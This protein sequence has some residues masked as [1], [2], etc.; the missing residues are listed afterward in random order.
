MAIFRGAQGWFSLKVEGGPDFEVYRLSGHEEISRTYEFD[1]ELVSRVPGLDLVDLLGRRAL[2]TMADHSGANRLV[3]GSIRLAEELH[4]ANLFTHYHLVIVPRLWYLGQNRN[5]RIFQHRSVVQIIDEILREQK[6]RC[7][8][9]EWKLKEKYQPREY[10]VQY[11]E[12]DLYF[13]SRL[14]EEE[15]IYYYFEHQADSHVLCFSDASGG[16]DIPNQP[17]GLLRFFPGSGQVADEAVVRNLVVKRTVNSDTASYREWN[18]EKPF[19]DLEVSSHEADQA[20]APAPGGLKLETYQYPHLY[21]LKEPGERYSRIQLAR[22]LTFS[23]VAEGA[24]DVTRLLPGF[25]FKVYGHPRPE[26]NGLWWLT[27]VRH[28]GEQPQVLE[29]EAPERGFTY[30]NSFTAIPFETRFIP[31]LA[32]PKK[33]INGLQSALVTG[34]EG[35]EVFVDEYGRVKVHFHWDRLGPLN[36]RSTRWVRVAADWAGMNF[37]YIQ[38]PRIGQEVLVEFMEG[39]PDRPVVTG[40]VYK[41][42]HMPPWELPSQKALSGLQTR[43]FHG[44]P[45]NQLVMDDT[46]GQIQLQVSSDYMFSQMNLGYLTRLNHISGRDDFRGKGFELRTDGWGAVRAGKG[47]FITTYARPEAAS[48]HKDMIE[49]LDCLEAGLNLHKEQAQRAARNLAQPDEADETLPGLET[50]FLDAK[51]SGAA[52]GEM[53][54]PHLL[55]SSP[56]GL[57]ADTPQ[58]AHRAAGE[59]QALTAGKNISLAAGLSL[60]VSTARRIG[61]FAAEAGLKLFAAKGKVEIQAQDDDVEIIADKVLKIISAKERIHISA[62]EEI[63]LTGADSYVRIN[64]GGVTSGTPAKFMSYAGSHSLTGPRNKDYLNPTLPVVA[65]CLL[66][67]QRCVRPACPLCGKSQ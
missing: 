61:L 15:G 43:E 39:D 64:S 34:P 19:L 30:G 59:H 33:T 67:A 10:C 42:E 40:R 48:H 22:Q 2:L 63:L 8:E 45:K 53:A 57:A 26:A 4:T 51:G 1:L 20:L 35:E 47:L 32:H 7:E 44:Q 13:I 38:P 17:E 54:A 31:E 58:T 16:P 5:H 36:D 49:T 66:E 24:G 56:A 6:F 52:H 25:S 41:K 9:V 14:C 55:I 23:K 11:D 50:Q 60:V 65:E 27:E 28:Y 37:G 3:H 18:F 12:S 21:E 62:P 29:H 46:P